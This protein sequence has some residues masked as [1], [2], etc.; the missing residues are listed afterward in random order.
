[1]LETLNTLW[2][3]DIRVN[4]RTGYIVVQKVPAGT[5]KKGFV[6]IIGSAGFSPCQIDD[7]E[8]DFYELA[9]TE[10]LNIM[11]LNLLNSLAYRNYIVVQPVL[12]DDGWGFRLD[13]YCEEKNRITDI[14]S[15]LNAQ[16]F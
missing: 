14:I 1:M 9:I 2:N 7:M 6:P 10:E 3:E 15:R 16:E 13:K 12:E 8:K 11:I 4:I 5:N